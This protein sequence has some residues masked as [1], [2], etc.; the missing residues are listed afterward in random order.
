MRRRVIASEDPHRCDECAAAGFGI[1][2]VFSGAEYHMRTSDSAETFRA[3]WMIA[4]QRLRAKYV[5]D[6]LE[7][8]RGRGHRWWPTDDGDVVDLWAGTYLMNDA[9]HRSSRPLRDDERERA[10]KAGWLTT[11]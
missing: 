4:C 7:A 1:C 8:F 2:R 6:G 11:S 9:P 5:E 10:V 3:R